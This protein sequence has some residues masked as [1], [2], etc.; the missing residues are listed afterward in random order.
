MATASMCRGEP[1][2]SPRATAYRGYDRSCPY[3][4]CDRPL[5]RRSPG[6]APR[7]GGSFPASRVPAREDRSLTVALSGLPEN[8]TIL[9]MITSGGPD[10][11]GTAR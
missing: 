8:R 6:P 7:D 5:A 2:L 1:G 3:R 11:A 4:G 10:R 9:D